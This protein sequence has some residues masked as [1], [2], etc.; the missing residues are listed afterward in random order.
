MDILITGGTGFLG[1]NLLKEFATNN[2]TTIIPYFTYNRVYMIIRDRKPDWLSDYPI[3]FIQCDLTDSGK[4]NDYFPEKIDLVIHFAGEVK[5][6]QDDKWSA[7]LVDNNFI[8]TL[9]LIRAMI[10]K[11]AKNL[12]YSSSMTVYGLNNEIPV[13]ENGNL[14]PIHFYGLTKKWAEDAIKY[15]SNKNLIKSL[16]L[17]LPG[18]YGGLRNSGYV[19]NLIR[20]MSKNQDIEINTE[21]LKFWETI[22]IDDAVKIIKKLLDIYKWEKNCE[23]INCSYGKKTDFIG[24]AYKVKEILNSKSTINVKKPIDYKKFYLDNSKLKSMIDF[25]YNFEKSLENYVEHYLC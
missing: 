12:V 23:I 2:I 21:G 8:S 1:S 17:R 20:K 13:K 5:I 7:S 22:N 14:D 3:N 9:N 10:N 15:Y 11:K 6:N 19:Y 4:L 24:T 25:D 18:L 16:I